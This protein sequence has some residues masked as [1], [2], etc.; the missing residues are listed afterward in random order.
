[1]LRRDG[2]LKVLDFG[3]AKLSE[4]LDQTEKDKSEAPTRALVQTAAGVVMGTTLYMSP[5]QARGQE[6]DARSDIWSLGC[7]LYEMLAGRA[8]FAGE[9]PS[10]VIVS[11]LDEEPPPLAAQA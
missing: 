6:T 10:H 2:Y 4:N 11:I 9:T 7:V 5:E 8:P 3:L 1:M